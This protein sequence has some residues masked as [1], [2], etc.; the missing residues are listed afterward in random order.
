[1]FVGSIY[2]WLVNLDSVMIPRYLRKAGDLRSL[3]I[4]SER[5][6]LPVWLVRRSTSAGCAAAVACT[7]GFAGSLEG[8][9]GTTK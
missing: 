9:A 3:V 4:G 6:T 8:A 2:S 1:M 5:L 7:S